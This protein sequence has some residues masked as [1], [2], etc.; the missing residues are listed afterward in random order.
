[1]HRDVSDALALQMDLRQAVARG[2]FRVSYQL[3]C[4]PATS[5]ISGFEA[6]VRWQHPD[7]GLVTPLAF[8]PVA[9]EIGVIRDIGRFVLQDACVRLHEWNELFPDHNIHMNI[10]VSGDELRDPAFVVYLQSMLEQTGVHPEQ[11]QLE[12]T[13]S[14]FLRQ[15][16]VIG[17]VLEAVRALGV[18]IALDDF[19][20]G[21]S[22]LSYIDQYPIDA[23]KI[24]RSFVARMLSHRR[25]LAIIET[26]IR[27]GQALDLQIVAEGVE[28]DEQRRM[29]T[30]LQCSHAQGYLF[31]T[32][33]SAADAT[34]ALGAQHSQRTKG[35]LGLRGKLGRALA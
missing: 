9:E 20:T 13:E 16:E 5:L 24:D 35:A 29:L 23:I 14:V 32:P 30:S 2:E 7:R 3:I 17:T 31:A 19:G 26:I 34:A 33:M 22:S 28:T 1:M 11:L 6:L 21:F 18:R 10:N 27:L 15:P 4:D 8:V 12:I 25:T